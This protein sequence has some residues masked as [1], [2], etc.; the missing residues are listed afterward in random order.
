[1]VIRSGKVENTGGLSQW[2]RISTEP[3]ET[4]IKL[5]PGKVS[6]ASFETEIL[7]WDDKSRV[8]AS[9]LG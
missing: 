7:R 8:E 9:H 4:S 6:M 2:D 1:M 3:N 5:C